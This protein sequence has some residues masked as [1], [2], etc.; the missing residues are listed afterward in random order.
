M[1][2]RKPSSSS[3]PSRRASQQHESSSTR[4]S[5]QVAGIASTGWSTPRS[6]A[7]AST[8]LKAVCTAS[9][10]RP[11]QPAMPIKAPNVPIR[12]QAEAHGERRCAQH[13]AVVDGL[14]SVANQVAEAPGIVRRWRR[15]QALPA[16]GGGGR[17][18][19][20]VAEAAA[21]GGGGRHC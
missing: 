21:G 18:C 10:R 15:R 11:C 13:I 6:V 16:G 2:A 8:A 14:H 1:A 7:H 17:H 9:Q 4:R 3:K 5:A 20:Q 12:V 19:Q